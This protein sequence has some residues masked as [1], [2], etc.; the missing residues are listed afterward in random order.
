MSENDSRLEAKFPFRP[1]QVP[2]PVNAELCGLL[3][4]LS[5]TPRLPV[6]V[7]VCVG[8]NVTLIV[9]CCSAARLLVQV[10]DDTAKSPVVLMLM[11]V[12]ATAWLLVKVNV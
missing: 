1:T 2:V 11:P 4:A 10:V 5:L 8:V 3:L 6:L 7:P 9:Q 12:S